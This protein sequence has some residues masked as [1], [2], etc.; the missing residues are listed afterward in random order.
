MLEAVILPA[1]GTR[2]WLDLCLV[3]KRSDAFGAFGTRRRPNDIGVN[4]S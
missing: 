4:K 1:S 2:T 3:D